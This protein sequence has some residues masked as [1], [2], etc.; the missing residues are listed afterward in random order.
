MKTLKI[1][2]A[3]R[4]AAVGEVVA[5]RER[6]DHQLDRRSDRFAADGAVDGGARLAGA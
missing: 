3:E 1:C 4:L 2:R 5:V 6:Q